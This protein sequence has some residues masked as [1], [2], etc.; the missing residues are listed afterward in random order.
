MVGSVTYLHEFDTF[1]G[2]ERE[3]SGHSALETRVGS[4]QVL[5]ELAIGA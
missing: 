3:Y 2:F 1:H 5:E 4:V